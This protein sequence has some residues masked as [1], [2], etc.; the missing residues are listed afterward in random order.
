MESFRKTEIKT[1]CFVNRIIIGVVLLAIQS[2]SPSF[3]QTSGPVTFQNFDFVELRGRFGHDAAIP[4]SGEPIAGF[5]HTA[6][7]SLFG[8][9]NTAEFKLISLTGQ[10][11]Q[12]INLAIPFDDGIRTGFAEFMGSVTPPNQPFQVVVTGLDTLGVTYEIA[13][14]KVFLPQL[15]EVS[16][17]RETFDKV[18]DTATLFIVVTNHGG[19]DTFSIDVEEVA[20]EFSTEQKRNSALSLITRIAPLSLTLN[21]GESGEVEL[22]VTSA[23][24]T[25]IDTGVTLTARAISDTNPNNSNNDVLI[26][27]I[28]I[29]TTPPVVTPPQDVIDN[30]TATL[31]QVAI[32]QATATDNV[33]VKS[34]ISNSPGQFPVGTTK[35]TWIAI[36]DAGNMGTATQNVTV[37]GGD[38]TPPNITPPPDKS[39]EAT[40]PETSVDIGTATASDNVTPEIDII[41]SNNAP[42]TF[43][44]GTTVVTWTATDAVN[45]SAMATQNV[46]VFDTIA[47]VVIPPPDKTV[48]PTDS[49]MVVDIGNATATDAV[50][51]VSLINDAPPSFP[52]DSTTEVKWT[53]TDAAGN[54]GMAVQRVT[55]SPFLLTLVIDKAKVKLHSKKPNNDDFKVKGKYSLFS[56]SDGFDLSTEDVIVV[57]G[58]F[59]E[60]IPVGSFVRKGN[61]WEFKG[62]DGGVKK[63]KV[64]DDGKFKVEG[65]NLNLGGNDFNNPV[66]FSIAIGNDFGETSILFDRKLKFKK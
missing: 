46:M 1:P 20:I 35:V 17:N 16:F 22:D 62:S 19:T 47:P 44:V 23:P 29:D 63:M 50:G 48:N 41:I 53:A 3:A 30:S 61:K 7:A 36:D 55:V 27:P 9:F 12:T 40:E 10:T 59:S 54:S 2:I 43:P 60:T 31:T 42:A 34:V 13:F 28:A 49:P 33:G 14:P 6:I 37:S 4:L 56:N 32:G 21:N 15:V 65:E 25:P 45:N 51:V 58:D 5:E 18:G 11:I 8:P 24:G 26:F 57:F 64:K 39:A 38:T 66:L 52:V